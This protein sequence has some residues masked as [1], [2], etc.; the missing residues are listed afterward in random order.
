MVMALESDF[1]QEFGDEAM[2]YFSMLAANPPGGSIENVTH[3][4]V[5]DLISHLKG[6]L[7]PA[8]EASIS[9]PG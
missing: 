6:K 7:P 8:P 1:Q 2:T 4:H 3:E 5:A 9:E